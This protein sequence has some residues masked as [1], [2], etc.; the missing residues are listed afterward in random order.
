M[1]YLKSAATL[2]QRTTPQRERARADQVPNSAGGHVFALEPLARLRRFLILGSEGGTYYAGERKLTRQNLENL[3]A[4]ITAEGPAAVE[5]IRDISVRGL[6]HRQDTTLW[7]LAAAAS[8]TDLATRRA[9]FAA[10][11]EVCRTGTMLFGFVDA[12]QTMRGWGR[13]MRRA[14]GAWYS[15]RELD[16]LAY[17][18]VKYRQRGGWS[19]ADLLRKAHPGL[20]AAARTSFLETA[21]EA[22]RGPL[23]DWITNPLRKRPVEINEAA[24]PQIVRGFIAV[25]K[26]GVTAEQAAG[27]IRAHDLPREAI[28][29]ELLTDKAVQEALLEKTPVTALIRNLGNYT[30]SGVIGPMR[31]GATPHVEQLLVNADAI[32]KAR[33]HPMTILLA[34]S[35]YRQGTGFRGDGAWDPVAEVVAALDEAFYLAFENVE[36]AN[37]RTM[38]ALDV[39]GSMGH[40]IANSMLTCREAAAAMA[41]ATLRSEPK[42]MTAAFT[43]RLDGYGHRGRVIPPV[44]K[45]S[46]VRNGY[47]WS[48][49]SAISIL[50]LTPKM[51]LGDVIRE[52]GGLAFGPTDCALPMLYALDKGLEV[53]TFIVYTDNETWH[54]QVHPF[55]ALKQYR[56]KMGIDAKLIVVGMTSTGFS[57]ADPTDPGMLDVVGF[58]ASAPA[59][60]AAFARGEL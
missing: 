37:K 29:S 48:G 49:S 21:D 31:A 3:E 34:L 55:Q 53:D 4:V 30:K 58:D 43:G 45:G 10:V 46:T 51:G 24:L 47:G 6:A 28:P 27:L 7:A 42:V 9:A 11:P 22:D 38:L 56:Q 44:Y 59:T 8:S 35:T 41:M 1:S 19:H 40:P 13:A 50:P 32:R 52:T 23:Y 25:S 16:Q 18:V 5:L 33:V 26:P 57:I 36:P 12:A 20:S 39:S 14:V 17:Q 54:G 15:E 2:G 60:M